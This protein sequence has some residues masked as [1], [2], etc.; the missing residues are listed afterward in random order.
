MSPTQRVKIGVVGCGDIAQIQHL[1]ALKELAEEF[2]VTTV[3]DVSPSLAKYVADWFDVPQYTT[4]YRQLLDSDLD[5]VLLCHRD[6]KTEVAVASLEARKHT[7]IEKPMCYSLREADRIIEAAEASGRVAQVGYMKLHEPAFELA[8]QEVATAEDVRFVQVNHLHPS[9]DLH[10]GQFRTRHFDDIPESAREQSQ[11]AQHEAVAEAIGEVPPKLRSMFFTVSGSM[12]HDLYG[13]RALFGMPSRVVSTEIWDRAIT[14]VFEYP[15]GHRCVASWVDLPQ[16]WDFHETLEVYGS[17]KRVIVSYTTG[18]QKAVSTLTVYDL[19]DQGR[20]VRREPALD[21]E[22]PFRR[23]LRHFH[24][25]IVND[26]EPRASVQSARDDV[27]LVI[28]IIRAG[29]SGGPVEV[30]AS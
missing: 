27:S 1:P 29:H 30:Q 8:Q 23:E 24:D 28:D 9:N 25:C 4:D 12:I 20:T 19:D 5:A 6:P 10:V 11:R 26:N 14:T 2:E 22:N 16:I 3:C 13:L 21:W 17:S 15:E 7:F 18:F